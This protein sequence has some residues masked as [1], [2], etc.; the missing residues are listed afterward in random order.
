MS[1]PL[2]G[3]DSSVLINAFLEEQPHHRIARAALAQAAG[4]PV[5]AYFETYS[6]LTRMPPPARRSAESVAASIKALKRTPLGLPAREQMRL[7]DSL[8]SLGVHGGATYDALVAATAKHHGYHLMSVD[9][10]A[11]RTYRAIGVDY[12]IIG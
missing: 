6:V 8:A 4:V 5:H 10:R 1:A 2:V 3:C 7:W 9:R 11:E 12:E